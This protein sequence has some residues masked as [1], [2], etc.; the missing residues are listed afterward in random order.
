MKYDYAAR[1]GTKRGRKPRAARPHRDDPDLQD[2]VEKQHDASREL[3]DFLNKR[4][5][6]HNENP[7]PFM[8]AIPRVDCPYC[9][10]LMQS[11]CRP[12]ECPT[13]GANEPTHTVMDNCVD[14]WH[15]PLA[16]QDQA[17][18]K[19]TDNGRNAAPSPH[20]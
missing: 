7:I 18:L 17:L 14:P 5:I 4:I 19:T 1:P 13:C 8:A 11:T 20:G 12:P 16:H 9:V 2:L 10:V 3:R 6:A 15:L